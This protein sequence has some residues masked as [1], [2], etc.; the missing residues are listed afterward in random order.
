[1]SNDKRSEFEAAKRIV[2]FLH[3]IDWSASTKEWKYARVA[4]ILEECWQAHAG[5]A[6]Q[7]L[8]KHLERIEFHCLDIIDRLGTSNCSRYGE[9]EWGRRNK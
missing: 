5:S 7:P 1:M 2:Q 8:D 3:D 9:P 6:E 4:E